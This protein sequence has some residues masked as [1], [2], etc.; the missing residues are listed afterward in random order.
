LKRLWWCCVLRDRILPLGVRRP[1]NISSVDFDFGV[2]PLTKDDF[3]TEIDR[4]KV[5]DSSTKYIL[6]EIF[7]TLCDLAIT[8][9]DVIMLVY[10]LSE[11]SGEYSSS[12]LQAD[13]ALS[14]VEAC[15][16]GLNRWF[17]K[18]TLCFPTPAGLGDMHESVILY[19]N[20]MYMYHQ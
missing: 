14:R 2:A 20:L 9:T 1:L 15:K 10:P 17:E 6:I 5:Y 13:H 12:D 11:P 8:L 18:A 19:T 16:S 7:L 4:S 3:E